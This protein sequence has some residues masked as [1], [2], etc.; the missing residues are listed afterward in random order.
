MQNETGAA[1]GKAAPTTAPVRGVITYISTSADINQPIT[2]NEPLPPICETD[3]SRCGS[4][5]SSDGPCPRYS[6]R[7]CPLRKDPRYAIDQDTPP[8][9]T[10]GPVALFT[11]GNPEWYTPP[12]IIEAV[13]D[14]FGGTIDLDPCS[15]TEGDR[16]HV[17]A[18]AHY[19]REDDGLSRAWHG[20]V[21]MNPPYGRGI[22]PW[23]EKIRTEYEAGR[24]TAAV[25]LVK[26][27]TDTA[28]FRI[29]SEK[30]P[31]CEVAGRLK[32]SGCGSPAPFPSTVFYLG[33]Q[34][35]RFAKVF[36]GF[37]VIVVPWSGAPVT[38]AEVV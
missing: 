5:L 13:L 7:G 2:P 1:P 14:L 32:F 3:P 24:V 27:A 16:P 15:N 37:G 12:E 19:T 20:R 34:V 36:G 25:V 4:F 23:I 17:P 21:Y 8:G 26:S 33:D 18:A 38:R 29:L 6:R 28:W 35:Q 11:S 22:R 9:E 30:Y 10:P 31:R